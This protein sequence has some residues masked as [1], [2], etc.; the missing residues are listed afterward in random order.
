MPEC[1]EVE[2]YDSS[3]EYS[4]DERIE[5]IYQGWGAREMAE[6]IVELEDELGADVDGICTGMYAD[7]AEAHAEIE[8]LSLDLRVSEAKMGGAALHV[9][10]VN[11]RVAMLENVVTAFDG[12]LGERDRYR[13]AWLSARRRAADEANMGAEAVDHIR[14]DRDRW[15]SGHETAEAQLVRERRESGRLRA[16]ADEVTHIRGWCMAGDVYRSHLTPI[17]EAL[18]ELDEAQREN[19][20]FRARLERQAIR[21]DFDEVSEAPQNV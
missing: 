7:V 18:Q 1:G 15:R 11:A 5:T 20:P 12:I 3:D 17:Y 21:G 9:D 6:R 8:R 4:R 16:F 10:R 2:V 19:R 13:L 14:R